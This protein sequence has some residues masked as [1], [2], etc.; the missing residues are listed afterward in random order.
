MIEKAGMSKAEIPLRVV[1][2]TY[3][4]A[5]NLEPLVRAVLAEPKAGVVVVDDNSPDGTGELADRLA[6]ET[7]RVEVVHRPAKGGLG[8][9]YR[10]GFRRALELGAAQVVTMDADFS[11]DPAM[12]PK[13]LEASERFDL[14]IGSRY[15]RGVSVINWSIQRILLSWFAN[16]YVR[17]ITGL[18][19][20]D[21]TSGYRLYRRELLERIGLEQIRSSGY[22]FLVEM[23]CRA[24]WRGFRV[25]EIQIIFAER[26]QGRSKLSRRDIAEAA[27]TPWRLRLRRM[28]GRWPGK[29]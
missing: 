2:P 20:T 27:L 5:A 10:A 9:A 6:A 14:V 17:A 23:A 13:F 4:E 25:G 3:N 8:T 18:E 22:S 1:I 11:H 7:G 16:T 21:C 19:L 24:A 28:L 26:R 29:G 12:L 15:L